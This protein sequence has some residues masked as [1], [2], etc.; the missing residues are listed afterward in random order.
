RCNPGS[1]NAP[2][3]W[4]RCARWRPPVVN[5]TS[6][7]AAVRPG[8]RAFLRLRRRRPRAPQDARNKHEPQGSAVA[9]AGAMGITSG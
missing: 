1:T 8:S 7:T 9:V 5:P 3:R 2:V 6:T 4:G